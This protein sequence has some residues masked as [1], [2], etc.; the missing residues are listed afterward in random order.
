[1]KTTSEKSKTANPSCPD[2]DY[3]PETWMEYDRELW[4]AMQKF[5]S[6]NS[7]ERKCLDPAQGSHEIKKA[8]F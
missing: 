3:P 2:Y 7:T 6:Q 5:E 4:N 8:I 1:M